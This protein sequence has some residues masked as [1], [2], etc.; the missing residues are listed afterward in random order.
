MKK[1]LLPFIGILAFASCEKKIDLDVNEGPKNI[2]I[3]G[4]VSNKPGPYT[5]NLSITQDYNDSGSQKQLSGATVVIIENDGQLSDTLVEVQE[6]VYETT[7][8]QGVV[9][10]F[11]QL[12]INT[13]EGVEYESSVEEMIQVPVIDSL[14]FRKK[15]EIDPNVFLEDGYYGLIAYQDPPEVR[16]FYRYKFSIDSVY[17]AN[18]GDI[19][20]SD[21]TFTDGLYVQ[22]LDAPYVLKVG[23]SFKVT[24][25]AISSSRYNYLSN[26][27]QLL[28][29][30]GGPFSPPAAPVIGN[31]FK[32]GS[33]SE[34]ALGY[35]QVTSETSAEGVV[36][37]R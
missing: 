1:L 30:N 33:V 5:V 36:E 24:Q 18:A 3:D 4:G 20:I 32:K 8:I 35:F 19:L 13:E 28:L 29:A 34:Y 7:K 6:G 23:Q 37:Q 11:Y 2:V 17:Q 10:S 12:Y 9:G 22:D 16:N 15:E 27:Q 14:Y 21:D 31:V 25:I 26:L